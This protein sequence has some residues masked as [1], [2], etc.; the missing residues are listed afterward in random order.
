[1]PELEEPLDF[2]DTPQDVEWS[3]PESTPEEKIEANR[4]EKYTDIK[5]KRKAIIYDLQNDVL[6]DEVIDNLPL[7]VKTLAVQAPKLRKL[8]DGRFII[9]TGGDTKAKG[10]AT[11]LI[12]FIQNGAG[13][14]LSSTAMEEVK[15]IIKSIAIEIERKLPPIKSGSN[16]LKVLIRLLKNGTVDEAIQ[17]YLKINHYDI[18]GQE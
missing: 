8:E 2:G 4:Y 6:P 17:Y 13:D 16:P 9:P 1:M 15:K 11:K 18:F 7:F 12:N 5:D 3:A 14:A 10:Y